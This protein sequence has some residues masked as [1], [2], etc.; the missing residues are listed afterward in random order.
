VDIKTLREAQ[1][2]VADAI[3]F[4]TTVRD[5]ESEKYEDRSD[6]WK[7]SEK[8]QEVEGLIEQLSG[9][10]DTLESIDGDIEEVIKGG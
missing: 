1:A 7:E 3:T 6:E 8:G 4:V 2:R 5:D 10:I 9:I